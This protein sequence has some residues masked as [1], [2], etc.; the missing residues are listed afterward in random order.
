[1]N[2][3]V[4]KSVYF[5]GNSYTGYNDLPNLIQQVAISTNDM[6]TYQAHTPGGQTLQNQLQDQNVV[7]TIQ[8][9]VW[10]YVVLQEQ[11][12]LP[13]FGDAATFPYA[14]QLSD[15]IKKSSLCSKVMFYMTWG[16]K[17]G[18]A[19]NCANGLTYV[20]TYEDMD[21]KIYDTYMRLGKANQGKV[22]PVGKVRRVLRKEHPKLELYDSDNSHPTYLGSMVAAYTFYVMLFEKDPTAVPFNGNLTAAD[23]AIIKNVV[24]EVVFDDLKKWDFT[25]DSTTANFTFVSPIDNAS[26]DFTNTSK[27]G[28]SFLWNFGDGSQSTDAS[29]THTYTKN[30]TYTVVL[31]VYACGKSYTFEKE[32]V[33]DSLVDSG[34]DNGNEDDGNEDDGNTNGNTGNEEE[35]DLYVFPNPTLKDLSIFAD[36]LE[37]VYIYDM[38][39][40][41]FD[42]KAKFKSG[43]YNIEVSHFANGIYWLYVKTKTQSKYIKFVKK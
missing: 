6:L 43:F 42:V 18:D 9:N 17:N 26:V 13:T 35:I 28:E 8:T 7:N 4:T 23:A 5:I 34:G 14:K 39:G 10:D 1:M 41:R 33:I 20:C 37:S 36:N 31:T 3:Q 27:N 30:G 32:V 16:Y 11:S 38:V 29:P 12:Q 2:A 22:S 25:I 19:Q 15:L 24:K 40:K 21:D